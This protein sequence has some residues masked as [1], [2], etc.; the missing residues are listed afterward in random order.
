LD[1]TND[2]VTVPSSSSLNQTSQ[3]SIAAWIKAD[4]WTG[5]NPR[6]VQKGINDTQYRLLF[7]NGNLVFSIAGKGTIAAPPPPNGV[8]HFVVG[9][10]DGAAMRLYVDNVLVASTT[11]TGALPTT[12]EPLAIG[13]K[14]TSAD[15]RDPFDGVIDEVSIH[16]VGLTAAAIDQLWD[17]GTGPASNTPPA[18]VINTPTASTTWEVGETIGFS[19]SATD[20]EDGA[21]PAASL[22]WKITIQHCPSNCHPHDVQ[23]TPGVS[24][25]SFAAPDHLYPSWLD[26]TLTATDSDGDSASVTRR[27]DPRTVT[28]TFTTVPAGLQLDVNGE[29]STGPFTRTVIEGSNNT[30][31]APSPQSLGGTTY[32]FQSWSDGGAASHSVLAPTSA[33]YTATFAASGNTTTLVPTADAEIRQNKP[34]RNFG[35]LSTLRV[36]SGQYRSYLKFDVPTLAGPVQSAKLRV[37]VVEPSTSGGSAFLVGNS[38]TETGITWSNAPAISGVPL[39]TAGSAANGTWVEFTVTSAVASSATVSFALTLGSADAVD[40]ASRTGTNPPQLVIVT[41]P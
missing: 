20:Q 14:P 18:P 34:T 3:L 7:E 11:A 19:G 2:Q 41:S 4:D 27:I 32:T 23:T 13:N 39:H 31:I 1:G 17:A 38:W 6:I 30:L 28:L 8:R 22:S 5:R 16:S 35:T 37:F 10:Y 21:I 29:P 15:A 36:K 26:I 24:S 33:T 12:T 40:Y 9:T 25:G